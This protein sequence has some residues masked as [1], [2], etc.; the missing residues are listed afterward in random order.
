MMVKQSQSW[1]E[2][3]RA[4]SQCQPWLEEQVKAA[5]HSHLLSEEGVRADAR[6]FYPGFPFPSTPLKVG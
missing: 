2:D 1:I 3:L 6:R 5:R 4:A